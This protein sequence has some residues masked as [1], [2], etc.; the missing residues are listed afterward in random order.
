MFASM[1]AVTFDWLTR[2]SRSPPLPPSNAVG[3][4]PMPSLW[5]TTLATQMLTNLR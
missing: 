4:L 2:A 3:P 1:Y 5:L